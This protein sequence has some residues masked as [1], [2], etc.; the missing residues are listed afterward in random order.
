MLAIHHYARGIAFAA[1]G[2][3]EDARAELAKFDAQTAT[4]PE[5]WWIFSNKAHDVLP[6]GHFML[7]GELAYR[8]GRLEDAWKAL[9]K[10]IEVEDRLIYDEPPG[11]MIPV[12][13]SMGALLMEAGLPEE[14]ERLYLE[15]QINHPG[16]GWSLLGLRQ[17]LEAQG[18]ES[19]TVTVAA[20]LDEAWKR[21]EVRPT[22]SCLC[23]PLVK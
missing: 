15:D 23:A 11:W 4:V 2:Q 17:A 21:V 20:K 6:I 18:K 19:E 5:D 22:S 7:E 8:E 12:R 16:N 10:A 14:A 13:H 9:R 1:T 3:T